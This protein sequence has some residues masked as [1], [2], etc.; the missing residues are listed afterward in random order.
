MFNSTF[1]Y[2]VLAIIGGMAV[3]LQGQF[4][5][6]MDRNIGTFESMFITYGVGAVC[7]G[8]IMLLLKGGNLSAVATGIPLYTLLAGALGLVI[9]GTIGYTVP[10]LGMTAAFTLFLV[11]QF[12]LST[13]FD[14]FGWLDTEVRSI[15]LKQIAGLGIILTGTFMVTS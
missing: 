14:H 1:D 5:G 15:G 10:R 3:T 8:L 2:M 4:M 11:G 7:I 12:V 6:Q 13:L 9:V